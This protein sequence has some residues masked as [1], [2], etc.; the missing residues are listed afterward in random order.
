MLIIFASGQEQSFTLLLHRSLQFPAG[1]Q[2]QHH[3]AGGIGL[4]FALQSCHLTAR[5]IKYFTFPGEL[6]LQMLQ[7]LVLPLITSSLI[8]GVSSVKGKTSMKM[9]LQAICY[10]IITTV[11]AVFTGIVLVT[12]IK[13]G[14]SPVSASASSG[15]KVEA[16]H[17]VDAFLDLIRNMFPSNLVVAFFSKYKTVYPKSLGVVNLTQT[18]RLNDT[19]PMP[20]T[21]EGVN[22]L[23]LVV[24]CIAFGLILGSMGNEGKPLMDFFDC[25]NKATMHL[26]SIVIWYS[27]VGILFLVGGQILNLKDIRVVGLQLT[28]Y[29]LTVVTGLVIHSLLTLPL[30]YFVVTHKNPFRFMFGLLEPLAT[31][32]GTSSSAVTLPISIRCLEKNLNMDKRVT[33]FM[34]PVAATVTMEGTALYEAVAA[35]FIAQVHNMELDLGKIIIVSI[36]ATVAAVG[37]TGIPQG[38]MVSMA[39]VLT[40]IGLPLEGLSFI[41]AIDWML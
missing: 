37:A 30:I 13:P 1:S 29:T 22:I 39:I 11:M 16:V 2:H 34:L 21:S 18:S 5:E 4:G 28:M 26:I 35:I 7:M 6:L 36:T 23:G 14:K 25:L 41:I 15:G 24:F 8:T 19:V 40:S 33:R 17:T 20:G 9:G 31:A 12:L 3:T 27:P 32:F 38:G 10:Y